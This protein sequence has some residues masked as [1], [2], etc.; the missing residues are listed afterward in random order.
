M[1]NKIKFQN[2]KVNQINEFKFRE[3]NGNWKEL[4]V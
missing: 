1:K 2:V 4:R 3:K